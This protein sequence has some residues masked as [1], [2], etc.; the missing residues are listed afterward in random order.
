MSEYTTAEHR[1]GTN[2]ILSSVPQTKGEKQ[3]C[4]EVDNAGDRT[5]LSAGG[6]AFILAIFFYTNK[7]AFLSTLLRKNYGNSG[8]HMIVILFSWLKKH[9]GIPLKPKVFLPRESVCV[10]FSSNPSHAPT[11]AKSLA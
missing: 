1:N 5:A 11:C 7:P 8:S 4:L 2:L 3:D 9:F 6:K 10:S